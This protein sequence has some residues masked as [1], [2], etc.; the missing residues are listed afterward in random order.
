MLDVRGEADGVLLAVKV[1]PGASRTRWLGTWENRAKIAVAAPADKGA[2]NEA[3]V[4]YIAQKLGLRKRCVAI[5][6][7]TA[8]PL[9]TVRIQGV[10]VDRIRSV[11][12][13]R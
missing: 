13:E 11:F 6:A 1:V 9:K 8:S 2:A 10:E 4:A 12:G 3:L 7:G 5:V